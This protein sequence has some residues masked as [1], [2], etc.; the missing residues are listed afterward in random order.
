MAVLAKKGS[1]ARAVA[2]LDSTHGLRSK[3]D[4]TYWLVLRFQQLLS[5][6]VLKPGRSR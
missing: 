2:A 4:I 1:R 5:D 6:G 3:D